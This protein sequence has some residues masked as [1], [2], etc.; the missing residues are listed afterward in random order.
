MGC[1]QIKYNI[2]HQL[3]DQYPIR[4]MCLMLAVSR[5]G[6]YKW[7]RKLK[8]LNDDDYEKEIAA[9]IKKC[10]EKVKY[11]YGYRR[12]TI[13]L[14]RKY[15]INHKAV[16]RLMNKYNLSSR[17]RRNKRYNGFAQATYRYENKLKRKFYA[18]VPNSVWLTDIT[19]FRTVNGDL[20]LSAIK[21]LYDG[22]IVGSMIARNCKTTLVLDTFLQAINAFK[23]VENSHLLVH[24]DQGSQYTSNEYHQLLK[25]YHLEPSMSRPGTPIDNAP[26]ESFFSTLK[27]EWM[28][29]PEILT[30][31][32]VAVKVENYIQFYNN[33]R[34][35]TNL[36]MAPLEYRK[37][38]G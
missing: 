11:T 18:A 27:T 35:R 13:W 31:D 24:S 7:L 36:G 25:H 10:Q 8:E 38:V 30:A 5:S 14:N 2:I 19:Q 17:I 33:E 12:M 28:P 22:S 29:H 4:K 21:D 32:Q 37:L 15:K 26:M 34:I 16:L 20:Y 3:K 1:P 9:K 23:K 6:Y